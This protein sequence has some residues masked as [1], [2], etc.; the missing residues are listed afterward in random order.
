MAVDSG[1]LLGIYGLRH[2]G[3]MY[4]LQEVVRYGAAV[5]DNGPVIIDIEVGDRP[6]YLGAIVL[7]LAPSRWSELIER[8]L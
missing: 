7:D 6:L 1:R 3:E 2:D 8:A 5:F 4:L